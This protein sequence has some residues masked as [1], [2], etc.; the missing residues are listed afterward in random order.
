MSSRLSAELRRQIVER[1]GDRCEY[2]RIHQDDVVAS[3]QIDHVIAEK[4]GGTTTLEN[5]ALL[6]MLCNIR[7]GS[8]LSSVDPDSLAIVPLFDPRK[9]IRAEHFR[10]EGLAI[11][12]GS[13]EAGTTG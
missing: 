12:G 6:Y 5:L 13:S 7:K 4:H 2:C 3:H 10:M 8:D 1:A 11:V 9:Q